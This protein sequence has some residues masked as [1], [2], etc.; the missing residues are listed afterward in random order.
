M[1]AYIPPPPLSW[2][3]LGLLGLPLPISPIEHRWRFVAMEAW[4][5]PLPYVLAVRAVYGAAPRLATAP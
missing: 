1:D 2:A 4:V 3:H 5:L